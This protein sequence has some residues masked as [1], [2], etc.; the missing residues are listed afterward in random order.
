[1]ET[2]EPNQL[3]FEKRTDSM[4][5][6]MMKRRASS[7]PDD[8]WGWFEDFD[9]TPLHLIEKQGNHYAKQPL[10]RSLSLPGSKTAPPLYVLES[11]LETQQLWYATAG[12]RPKQPERERQYFEKLWEENF[13]KSSV[14]YSDSSTKSQS[15]LSLHDP[16]THVKVH[17]EPPPSEFDGE[18]L[19]RGKGSFSNSVSKSFEDSLMSSF[20]I[21]VCYET[22]DTCFLYFYL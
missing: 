10:Q 3:K 16:H 15:S 18:I 1:M 20:T 13:E 7:E 8:P 4:K 14:D 9:G 5:K 2:A 21:Q 19:F 6:S 17:D 11:S 12:Q 22:C